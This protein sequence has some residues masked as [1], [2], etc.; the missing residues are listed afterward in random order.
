MVIGAFA[1]AM[2]AEQIDGSES[3]AWIYGCDAAVKCESTAERERE[4]ERERSNPERD[5]NR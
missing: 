1:A 3:A 4:R 2:A 5:S